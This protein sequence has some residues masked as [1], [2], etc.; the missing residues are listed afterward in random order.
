MIDDELM[1][2]VGYDDIDYESIADDIK[3]SETLYLSVEEL[4]A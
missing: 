3:Y 1:I 2:P 4:I